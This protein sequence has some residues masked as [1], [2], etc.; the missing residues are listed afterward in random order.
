MKKI[1]DLNGIWDFKIGNKIEKINVPSNWYLQGYDFAGMAEYKRNINIKKSQDKKYFI[2]C[3]GIDYFSD[4]Y[5]NDKFAGNH[6]GY[7]QTFRFDIT[8]LLK[9]GNN[10]VKI[11]VNSPKE[12]DDIWPDKKI[13]IKGIF[14]HHDARPGSWNKKT[15]QDKNTGGIWNNVFI[16]EVEK[17]EI[18]RVKITP[19]LKDDGKWMVISE[20]FI[21]NFI[22]KSVE[23]SININILPY[24]FKGERYNKKEKIFLKHGLNKIN[25]SFELASPKLW[26]TWDFGKPNL[27]EFIYILQAD[28]YKDTLIEI[29]GIR[30]FKKGK[31]N[32][33]YLNN[34][35]IFLRGSNI[36]PTQW[37]SEYTNEKIK[38]DVKLIKEANLNIIRVHA[39]V[40]REEFYKELDREGIMVWQ[41]FALQ[42]SYDTSDKFTDNAVAQLKDMINIHYNRPSIV[43]WC[44]HNEPSV[45]EKQLDPVLEKKAREEDSLRHIEK[46]SDFGQHYYPGWYYDY[47]PQNLYFD[48]LKANKACVISEYGAQALPH[49]STLKKIFNENEIFPPDI[50]KWQYYDFQPEFTFN[51]AGVKIGNSIEEFIENSQNYQ[52]DLIKELTEFYRLCRYE[53]INGILHFMFVECWPSITWAVVDYFRI[54][55][56]GY[57]ALKE[58]MQPVYPGFRIIRKK[59]SKTEKI[60]WNN[61][62][63]MVYIINDLHK[64]INNVKFVLQVQDASEKIYLNLSKKIKTIIPDSITYP[65]SGIGFNENDKGSYIPDNVK[66]GIH[67]IKLFIYQGKKIIASNTYNFEV[68][69]KLK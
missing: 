62:L 7:F 24:N 25:I 3:K 35:R 5:I 23:A 30:E 53:N 50:N 42:W 22:K 14:N 56:K 16:E 45:N 54:P 34:K 21:N 12:S 41:D 1:I 52:A 2:V 47:S 43:I 28:E 11:I 59:I 18:E 58:A 39:H 9:N 17:I 60:T 29:S 13:L 48:M 31:D 38:K 19:I 37:L 27:Y 69:E 20:L 63:E 49:I 55:K 33:W 36:I 57:Y 8:E 6:E 10:D 40:N 26:W 64:E 66:S 44:C 46:A 61:I 4:I 32:F 67:K 15:G 51:I 68:V 65:F